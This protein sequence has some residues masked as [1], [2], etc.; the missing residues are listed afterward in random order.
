MHKEN[1]LA[2]TDQSE[3]FFSTPG[4]SG[5]KELKLSSKEVIPLASGG[6]GF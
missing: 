2:N 4:R 1:L 3:T 6:N 5:C